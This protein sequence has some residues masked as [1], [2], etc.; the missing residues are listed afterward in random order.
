MT[1]S[2]AT[3]T[4]TQFADLASRKIAY[5]MFGTGTPLI[6]AVRFR[7]TLDVWDPLFLARKIHG[8]QAGVAQ[9]IEIV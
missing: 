9:G 3:S 8:E 1:V 5:R 4:P 2:N 6:L 7:G